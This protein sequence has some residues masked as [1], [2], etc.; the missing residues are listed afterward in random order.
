MA[1]LGRIGAQSYSFRKF[2]LEGALD[3]LALLGLDTMEFCGV[4]IP[5]DPAHPLLGNAA[6]LLQARGV[7]VP[8]YGVEGFTADAA[9]NRRLFELGRALGVA[10]LTA[11]PAPEA[12]DSLE[13]LVDEFGIGIAI[14][15][16][17]PGA[18]YDRAADTLRAV[19]GRHPRIGACV[20]TGHCVRSGERPADV[21]AALGP[22]VLSVHLKDW[23]A[24]GAETILGEGDA[25]LPAVAA[26]LRAAGFCGPVIMEYEN[27]PDAPVAD[28]CKGLDHWKQFI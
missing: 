3:Q 1:D 9:A 18:R 23:K 10:F 28:M 15:N 7:R 25:D 17:G 27:S 24:G 11:D 14:H 26:A 6:A 20:D 8:C 4:H 16:H 2:S 22:R 5:A 13:E 19:A 21:I 12:F